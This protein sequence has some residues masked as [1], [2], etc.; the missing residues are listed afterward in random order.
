M[1]KVL[2]QKVRYG[3]SQQYNITNETKYISLFFF[4]LIDRRKK[5]FPGAFSP[6]RKVLYY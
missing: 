6:V 2:H 1:Y 3:H 5:R 4:K